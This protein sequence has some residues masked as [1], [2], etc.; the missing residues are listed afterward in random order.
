MYFVQETHKLVDELNQTLGFIP[1][2]C[3]SFIFVLS[4]GTLSDLRDN[5]NNFLFW[6]R[7]Q[8]MFTTTILCLLLALGIFVSN[9][10]DKMT[11]VRNSLVEE[12]NISP[13]KIKDKIVPIFCFSRHENYQFMAVLFEINTT[14]V[15]AFL[16]NIISFT[17]LFIQLESTSDSAGEG[18]GTVPTTFENN[19]ML[20][21]SNISSFAVS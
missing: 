2:I 6:I 1:F 3:Y 17:V 14:T 20:D 10:K 12:L 15:L 13:I 9:R 19:S 11:K 5:K 21:V 8:G 7:T 18:T 4:P 16:A